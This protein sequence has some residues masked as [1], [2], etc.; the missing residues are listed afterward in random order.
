MGQSEREKEGYKQRKTSSSSALIA[1][2]CVAE[3]GV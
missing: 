1:W 3:M 2:R